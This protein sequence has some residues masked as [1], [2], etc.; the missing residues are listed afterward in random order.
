MVKVS[1]ASRP[2]GEDAAVGHPAWHAL[3]SAK[4][5]DIIHTESSWLVL[6]TFIFSIIQ[7]GG[8]GGEILTSP[9][10]SIPWMSPK[11]SFQTF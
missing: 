9:T 10:T 11:L 2:R 8:R 1:T 5:I 3:P 6:N 7:N 4:L